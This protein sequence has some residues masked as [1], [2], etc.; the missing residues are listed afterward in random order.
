MGYQMIYTFFESLWLFLIYSFFGWL[1]ETT[2]AAVNQKRFVNRGLALVR[3]TQRANG[4][5][6]KQQWQ[7]IMDEGFDDERLAQIYPNALNTN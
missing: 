3:S 2:V 4:V 6:A 7:Q 5:P 1:L